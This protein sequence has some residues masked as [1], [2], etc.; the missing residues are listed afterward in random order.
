MSAFDFKKGDLVTWSDEAIRRL[1]K[2]PGKLGRVA[3]TPYQDRSVAVRWGTNKYL[4]YYHN[5]FLQKLE[6]ADPCVNQP[7]NTSAK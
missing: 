3:A 5:T 1:W 2:S 6:E 4:S 7:V